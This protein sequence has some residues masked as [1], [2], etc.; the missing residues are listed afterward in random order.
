MFCRPK[1]HSAAPTLSPFFSVANAIGDFASRERADMVAIATH[2]R[3][4]FARLIRGSVADAVMRS[5][6]VSMLVFKPENVAEKAES[7]SGGGVRAD[8][9]PI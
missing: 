2:G 4:G 5:A 7:P 6:R 9:I 8:L 3:G 1:R